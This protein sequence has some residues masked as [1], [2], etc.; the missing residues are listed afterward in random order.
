MHSFVPLAFLAES[1]G[2]GEVLL[3]FVVILLLFGPRRLPDIARQLGRAASELRRASQGF[4]DQVMQMDREAAG[5]RTAEPD[6]S[7]AGVGPSQG[8][9]AGF[10]PATAD[11]KS[12]LPPQDSAAMDRVSPLKA[13]GPESEEKKAP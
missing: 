10:T 9:R 7:A 8:G 4:R 3:L 6:E 11:V 1:V 2:F 5:S 13:A 12:A